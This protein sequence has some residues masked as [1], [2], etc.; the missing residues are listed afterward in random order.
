M[1]SGGCF[2]PFVK[3]VRII[4]NDTIS[5]VSLLK[6]GKSWLLWYGSW[7]RWDWITNKIDS[8]MYIHF[9]MDEV[10]SSKE[11]HFCSKIG[12]KSWEL[13]LI[14]GWNPKKP[15]LILQCTFDHRLSIHSRASLVWNVNLISMV[16]F[17][18][19]ELGSNCTNV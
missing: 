7:N 10:C 5:L 12:S 8:K 19:S 14:W 6:L 17:S 13:F 3:A 15:I 16:L 11:F 9:S 1:G 4:F 18:Y 2:N